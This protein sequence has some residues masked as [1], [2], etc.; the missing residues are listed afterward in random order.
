[1]RL[2]IQGHTWRTKIENLTFK[3]SEGVESFNIR[4]TTFVNDLEVLCGP[5]ADHKIVL[6]FL[7]SVPQPYKQMVMD[8]ESLLD[9]QTLSIE[10]FTDR[11][12]VI[13]EHGELEE[14]T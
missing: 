4:L 8:I 6:K 3:H 11:L 5:V 1:M 13:Q 12:L 7:Q 2:G 9:L 14:S 10:E